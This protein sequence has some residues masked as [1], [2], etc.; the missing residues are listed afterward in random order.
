M[1]TFRIWMH[2]LYG[3]GIRGFLDVEA[4]DVDRAL[5]AARAAPILDWRPEF[6]PE[7][8]EEQP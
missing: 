8:D 3:D 6:M 2:G 5:Q 1:I 7:P 4:E